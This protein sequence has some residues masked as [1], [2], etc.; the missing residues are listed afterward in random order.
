VAAADTAR[1]R[2]V[3][4]KNNVKTVM[5]VLKHRV[6]LELAASAARVEAATAARMPRRTG[7]S[8]D[9]G[10]VVKVSEH[11]P[12]YLVTFGHASLYLEYGTRYM[13]AQPSLI[14]SIVEEA[15]TLLRRL[16]ITTQGRIRSSDIVHYMD[17]AG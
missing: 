4:R 6:D 9:S 11:P 8:A 13:A 15:P 14:P 16:A 17:I 7:E 5:A 3:V 12:R 10:Q 2:W 1:I